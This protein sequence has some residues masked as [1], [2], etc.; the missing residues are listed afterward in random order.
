MDDTDADLSNFVLPQ[1]LWPQALVS[2][3]Y[4]CFRE[5]PHICAPL[6]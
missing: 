6:P 2:V 4:V 3:L 1:D 5:V